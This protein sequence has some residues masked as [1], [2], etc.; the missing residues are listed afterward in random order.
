[1]AGKKLKGRAF[2]NINGEDVL[3][4]EMDEDGKVTWYL[5]KEV[6]DPLQDKMMESVG[7]SMSRYL[8]NHP[9]SAL[10]GKTN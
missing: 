2:I 7:R 6:T 9:E 10:W 5:P 3:W 1:M 8:I 4:Y